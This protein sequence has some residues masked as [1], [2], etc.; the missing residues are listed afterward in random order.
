MTRAKYCISLRNPFQGMEPLAPIP[1]FRVA[2]TMSVSSRGCMVD[3]F[4]DEMQEGKKSQ[5]V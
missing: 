5:V 4:V 3:E 1:I 2:A